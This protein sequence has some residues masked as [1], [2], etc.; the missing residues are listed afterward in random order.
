[1]VLEGTKLIEFIQSLIKASQEANKT[2]LS[3]VYS[4]IQQIQQNSK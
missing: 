1:M 4:E 3:P 2:D